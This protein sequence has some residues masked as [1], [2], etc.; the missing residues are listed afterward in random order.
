MAWGLEIDDLKVFS[1]PNYSGIL[2]Q[3]EGTRSYKLASTNKPQLNIGKNSH[4]LPLYIQEPKMAKRELRFGVHPSTA[5]ALQCKIAPSYK[6]SIL[7]WL[8]RICEGA[9]ICMY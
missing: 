6:V 7:A 1:N 8:Q 9:K 4:H 5:M 3:K 2:S